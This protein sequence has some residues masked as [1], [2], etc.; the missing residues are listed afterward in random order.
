LFIDL[1]FD[2]PIT[3]WCQARKD[4]L[5]LLKRHEQWLMLIIPKETQDAT[6]PF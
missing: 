3:G 1:R 4:F 5:E 2:L 6:M